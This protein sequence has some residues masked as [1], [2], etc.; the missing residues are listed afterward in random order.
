METQQKN[1]PEM[2]A[3]ES[4][5][6]EAVGFEMVEGAGLHDG[7][8]S[9]KF[10]GGKVYR[11]LIIR[12]SK[13]QFP[14]DQDNGTKLHPNI[15]ACPRCGVLFIKTSQYSSVRES[16]GCCSHSVLKCPV[17]GLEEEDQG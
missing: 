4:S 16:C 13:F 2:I 1:N 3:V 8:L 6:V 5:N 12:I 11:V 14:N 10:K 15:V 7:I 9:V 17:C